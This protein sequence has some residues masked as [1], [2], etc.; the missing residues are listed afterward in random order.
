MVDDRELAPLSPGP[1]EDPAGHEHASARVRER[2]RRP[3]P[4]AD[5]EEQGGLLPAARAGAVP[6]HGR[7]GR[8][9]VRV[10]GEGV[11]DAHAAARE[12]RRRVAAVDGQRC[13]LHQHDVQVPDG[14]LQGSQHGD[15]RARAQGV[16]PEELAGAQHRSV[17][18]LDRNTT[19]SIVGI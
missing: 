7:A 6:Q 10:V 19:G 2:A 18:K 17:V 11:C 14:A 16:R 4:A 3:H 9:D 13:H 12:A 15:A 1:S 5:A 8:E